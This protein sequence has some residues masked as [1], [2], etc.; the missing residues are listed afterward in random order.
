MAQ[1]VFNIPDAR[2]PEVIEA[3]GRGRGWA[4]EIPDPN[5]IGQT[6]PN[7]ET[8]QQYA[9]K[10]IREDIQRHVKHYQGQQIEPI[11]IT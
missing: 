1:L 4:D 9:K 6:M 8:E 2:M 11:P 7:P 10:M 5:N 3:W